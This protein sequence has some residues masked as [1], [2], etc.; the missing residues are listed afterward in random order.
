MNNWICT[1]CTR[2]NIGKFCVNCGLAANAQFAPHFP[3]Q[4][5][6]QNQAQFPPHQPMQVS[7]QQSFQPPQQFAQPQM[8]PVSVPKSGGLQNLLIVGFAFGVFAFVIGF[9]V[10]V[11]VF[12]APGSAKVIPILIGLAGLLITVINTALVVRKIWRIKKSTKT[13][14]VVMNVESR[15]GMRQFDSST[16]N[17]LFTPTVRFQTAD[18]RTVDYTPKISTSTNNYQVGENV[19][20]YYDP[21]QP[22]NVIVGRFYNLWYLHFVFGLV[23]GMFLFGIAIFIL[24]TAKF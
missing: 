9:I 23:G 7:P 3:P 10:W 21:Q 11:A 13:T 14:G 19:P 2:Q 20:V 12:G 6:A 22:E 15:Q 8:P 4:F 18:G 24:V 1:K 16:R 17:T 5:Q